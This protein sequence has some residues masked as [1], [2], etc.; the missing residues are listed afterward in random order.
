MRPSEIG[1]IHNLSDAIQASQ[2]LT[3]NN[4]NFNVFR[5]QANADWELG[6]KVYRNAR[7]LRYE[8][9]M[10]RDVISSH[11]QE[12]Y[13]DESMLDKLVR[14]QHYGLPTRLL[15]VTLNFLVAL[16]FSSEECVEKS[17]G[18]RREIRRDGA[19]FSISGSSRY[20]KYYDSDSV[21]VITNL[22]NLTARRKQN[23]LTEIEGLSQ[24][25]FDDFKLEADMDQLFQFIRSEKPYF[26]NRIKMHDLTRSYYVI[27]KKN[28]RRIVAQ[29]G[30]FII[31]G[32]WDKSSGDFMLDFKVNFFRIPKDDKEGIREDLERLGINDAFLFPEI[33][34]AAAFVAERYRTS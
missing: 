32:L 25:E 34:R 29:S 5:G 7:W 22:S 23:I 24:E 1:V 26:K 9:A 27:P 30:A 14:L 2:N 33:D 15:D 4:F 17:V 3:L 8:H 31:C 6:P 19:L 13:S 28:N 12:F 18:S 11:P 10:I 21:S 20:R 16:Y